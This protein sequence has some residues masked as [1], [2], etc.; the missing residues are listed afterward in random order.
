MAKNK[1]NLE[2]YTLDSAMIFEDGIKKFFRNIGA[3]GK[4]EMIKYIAKSRGWK[5]PKEFDDMYSEPEM[6]IYEYLKWVAI[7]EIKDNM[8]DRDLLMTLAKAQEY[9]TIDEYE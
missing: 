7:D 3:E 6:L 5:S 1:K 9:A 2:Y 8:I 4:D